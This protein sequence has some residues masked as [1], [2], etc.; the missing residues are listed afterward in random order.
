V[1]LSHGEVLFC[2]TG[3]EG[4]YTDYTVLGNPLTHVYR[5]EEIAAANQI[6]TPLKSPVGSVVAE[7]RT[8]AYSTSLPTLTWHIALNDTKLRGA[9]NLGPLVVKTYSG[10][11]PR[12][13]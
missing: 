13:G 5:I 2:K 10:R 6:V 3:L 9:E 8:V 11:V 4:V 7:P 12:Q 1:A